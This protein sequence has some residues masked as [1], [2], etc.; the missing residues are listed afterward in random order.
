MARESTD[1]KLAIYTERLDRYIENQE[2]LNNRLVTS[3]EKLNTDIE[4]LHDWRS[5][6]MGAKTG[7]VAVGLL[8]THTVVVLG[9]M[10]ALVSWTNNR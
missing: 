4:R 7:L 1:V 5:R 8:I 6:M 10:V 9:S 3:V 2:A